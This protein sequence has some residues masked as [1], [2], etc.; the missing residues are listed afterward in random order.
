MHHLVN[1]S[2]PVSAETLASVLGTTSRTI[3]NDITVLD[4]VLNRINARIVSKKGVGYEIQAADPLEMRIFVDSFNEVIRVTPSAWV[5]D[6]VDLLIHALLFSPGPLKS[7][8]LADSL[9]V[10]RTTLSAD[11]RH[12]RSTLD[13]FHLSLGQRPGSGLSV[14]GSEAHRRLAMVAY[15]FVDEDMALPVV[16][17]VRLSLDTKRA[18]DI[19]S[20]LVVELGIHLSADSL[21]ELSTLACLCAARFDEGHLISLSPDERSELDAI[22]EVHVAAR[23]WQKAGWDMPIEELGYF[24][25]LLA[26]RRTYSMSDAFSLTEHKELFFLA[27]DLLRE[28]FFRTDVNLLL[29][30]EAR[31]LLARELRALRIRASFGFELQRSRN[32]EAERPQAI[33]E[34][35]V[36]IGNRLQDEHGIRLNEV[37]VANLALVLSIAMRGSEPAVRRKRIGVVFSQGLPVALDVAWRVDRLFPGLARTI[38]PREL[39]ELSARDLRRLDLI[40]TDIPRVKFPS[41]ARLVR[42]SP[43][44]DTASR[45]AIE[46]ALLDRR[47]A[48]EAFVELLDPDAF[49]PQL[50][51]DTPEQA[52]RTICE[53]LAAAPGVDAGLFEKVILRDSRLSTELGTNSAVAHSLVATAERTRVG[54]A[55]LR[56]PILWRNGPVQVVFVVANGRSEGYTF[57][58]VSQLKELLQQ[59]ALVDG[60]V[61]GQLEGFAEFGDLL[62][63]FL[64]G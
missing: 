4:R 50:A 28:L 55:I 35:A 44:L 22:E 38:E 15:L 41:G 14:T 52:L 45:A 7:E 36:L 60:L 23:F 61:R 49:V 63:S 6:R 30:E 39:H 16:P 31:L 9:H 25:L 56:R 26:S 43:S 12:V 11:L 33:V 13:Q 3:R 54:A 51:A 21:R 57:Q 58:T 53:R 42:T 10:S 24:A 8:D 64:V 37:E 20:E 59:P 46:D 47:E 62:F 32:T 29:N 27:D 34:Y 5:S 2:A 18:H 48:A 40:L 17:D 19:L 1:S